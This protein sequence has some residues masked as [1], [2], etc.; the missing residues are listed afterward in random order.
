MFGK[1]F[2]DED[3]QN[4]RVKRSLKLVS[5]IHIN[6]NFPQKTQV[7]F[8]VLPRFMEVRR[9]TFVAIIYLCQILI[10]IPKEHILQTQSSTRVLHCVSLTQFNKDFQVNPVIV[11]CTPETEHKTTGDK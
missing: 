4:P 7:F 10:E 11:R 1:A 3:T 5:S 2:L 8:V 9:Q 6:E